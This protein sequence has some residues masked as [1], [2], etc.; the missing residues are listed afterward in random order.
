MKRSKRAPMFATCGRTSINVLKITLRRLAPFINLKILPTRKILKSVI[1]DRSIEPAA[2]YTI[3]ST[4][5]MI[6]MAKSKRFT[7]SLKYIRPKAYIF[8]IASSIKIIVK[9]RLK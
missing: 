4:T 5:D 8:I 1:I 6:T 7:P 2:C 3:I 9:T